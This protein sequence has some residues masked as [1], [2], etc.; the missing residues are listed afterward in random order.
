MNEAVSRAAPLIDLRSDVLSPP[1]EEM[2]AA[3]AQAR[4]G[5]ALEGE[6]PSTFELEREAAQLLGMESAVFLP[7]CTIA[8]QLAI[9]ALGGQNALAIA[10]ENSHVARSEARGLRDVYGVPVLT[11]SEYEGK[12]ETVPLVATLRQTQYGSRRPVVVIENT[13]NFAGGVAFRPEDTTDVAMVA[14]RNQVPTLLDGARLFNAATALDLEPRDL[15]GH[16]DAVAISLSKGLCAPAGALF[17]GNRTTTEAVRE[18]AKAIGAARMHKLGYLAAAGLLA[19]R[20]MRNRLAEDHRR[21]ALLAQG[22]ANVPGLAL[23]PIA[24]RTNIV[25]VDVSRSRCGAGD[26]AVRLKQA[27]VGAF[28]MSPS[29]LRFC[30]HRGISDADVDRTISNVQQVVAEVILARVGPRKLRSNEI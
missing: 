29:R 24:I 8:N 18:L 6:D 25:M 19:L 3:M 27:G 2:F 30:L 1:T 23:V 22:L 7:S 4:V 16:L 10:G 20:T 17:V 5:W 21:A 15:T 11:V 9:K 12:P 13:H 14:H 26:I 28:P